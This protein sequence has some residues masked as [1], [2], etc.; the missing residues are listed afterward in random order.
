MELQNTQPAQHQAAAGVILRKDSVSGGTDAVAPTVGARTR[1]RSDRNPWSSV[2]SVAAETMLNRTVNRNRKKL[3]NTQPKPNSKFVRPGK[4]TRRGALLI[5]FCMIAALAAIAPPGAAAYTPS[6]SVL[7]IGLHYGTAAVP[8]GNLMN[9]SG[10]GK[11]FEFGYFDSDRS[12]RP[13]GA[14]TGES[15]ISMLVDKNMVWHPGVGGGSGEYREAEEG[16]TANVGCF[17]ITTGVRYSSFDEAVSA[18]SAYAE[19]FVKAVPSGFF[20]MIGKFAS[21]AEAESAIAAQGLSGCTIDAGTAHTVAV[22]KTGTHEMLFEFDYGGERQIGIMPIPE[23]GGKCETWCKG[24]RY[25]GGF[26]YVRSGGTLTIINYVTTEEYIKGIVPS[27]MNPAWHIEA[28]K[29]QA[30]CART[31]ALA[32]LNKH[33]ANGFDLCTTEHCQAYKGRNPASERSDRAVDET[34]GMYITYNGALCQTYY[35]S[36]NGGASENSEN[37]WND[38]LPYLRGVI[39][40]Y[41]ADV[42][43]KIAVY[44]WSVVYTPKQLTERLQSQGHNCA[45]IVSLVVSQYTLTGNVLSVTATDENGAKFTFSKRGG[46]MT[47]LGITTQRFN[48]GNAKWEGAKL[49]A[50]SPAVGVDPNSVFYGINA[51]GEVVQTQGSQIYAINGSGTVSL[52]DGGGGSGSGDGKIDGAFVIRGTGRG[53]NVGMS[54]WGAYSMAEYHGKTYAEI[55]KFYYTGVDIG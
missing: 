36:S 18:A 10:Y 55:I 49:Y 37:V 21:R 31:Y 6:V 15:A 8:S 26:Q 30:C 53:H 11:G 34:A 17:H 20:V 24:Y 2:A 13:I 51:A 43:S 3:Q 40:P 44:N 35:A 28:L 32:S 14:Y 39:D 7:R 19:S 27:E 54:Q 38:A 25:S 16:E 52:V 33:S 23:N 50:N 48:I 22:V 47:A 12:F 1:Q 42:A 29:A 9:N 41:E 5:A 4:L 45:T 46:L